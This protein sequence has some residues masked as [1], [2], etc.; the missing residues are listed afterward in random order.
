MDAWWPKLVEAEFEPA[1]GAKAYEHLQA[2]IKVG[3]HT[4]GSPTEPDFY[5]GW[6][7]FVSKDLRRL[8][9]PRPKGTWSRVYCGEGSKRDCRRALQRS[10]AAALKVTPEQLYGGGNGD[11]AS[12]PDPQC[13]DQNRPAVTSGVSLPP[14]PLQN[15]PTFQQVVTPTVKLP[16]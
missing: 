7:G 5:D 2:M 9:G 11:C 8:F 1:L 6:W 13:F 4:G 15:R 12:D 3:S 14:F 10:L 16:R